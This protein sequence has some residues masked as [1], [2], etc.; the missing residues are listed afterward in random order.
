MK[1]R[2]C[3]F[4]AITAGTVLATPIPIKVRARA[5]R[6]RSGILFATSI[7]TP[8]ASAARVATT[9][10]R[11]GGLMVTFFIVHLLAL[12]TCKPHAREKASDSQTLSSQATTMATPRT[13]TEISLTSGG[14]KDGDPIPVQF[15]CDG[16]NESPPLAWS[17]APGN[18]V[19]FALTVE[20]PDAPGGTF[21]HWVLYDIP[22]MT[23]ALPQGVPKGPTVSMLG[24]AKQGKT[25]FKNAIGYGGPCPPKGSAHHYH[26]ILYALDA[27]L[28]LEPGATHDQV[29]AAIHGHELARGELVGT[30]KRA[31]GRG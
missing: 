13:L 26:F 10:P 20:D 25:S 31:D 29:M 1:R 24:G 18:T 22:P 3:R 27:S 2:F 14:F 17:E 19:A 23:H 8:R 6:L 21:I 28:G 30:Y 16:T 9:K 12:E 5:L 15:T 7:P 4:T 11:V